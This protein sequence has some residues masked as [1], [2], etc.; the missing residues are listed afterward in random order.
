MNGIMDRA[1]EG[2][3]GVITIT[4]ALIG[5]IAWQANH[6]SL[7]LQLKDGDIPVNVLWASF[8]ERQMTFSYNHKTATIE[9][10]D[11]AIHGTIIRTFSTRMLEIEIEGFFG[12]MRHKR[13]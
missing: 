9:M 8:G 5:G 13:I 2:T 3:M 6:G 10:R 1:E 4:L 12:A 7:M 11:G